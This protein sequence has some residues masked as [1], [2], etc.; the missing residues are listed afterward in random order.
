MIFHDFNK[1]FLLSLTFDLDFVIRECACDSCGKHCS[2]IFMISIIMT[3]NSN[4]L[5]QSQLE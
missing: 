2:T 3:V 5:Y 1:L 4:C